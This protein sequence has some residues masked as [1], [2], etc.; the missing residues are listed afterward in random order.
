MEQKIV[1]STLAGVQGFRIL[2]IA[3]L[4]LIRFCYCVDLSEMRLIKKSD[5]VQAEF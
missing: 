3:M 2:Y 5:S 4:F 1:G